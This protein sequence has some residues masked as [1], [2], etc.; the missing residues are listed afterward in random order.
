MLLQSL[1]KFKSVYGVRGKN[2]GDMWYIMKWA[3]KLAYIE[4]REIVM[5]WKVIRI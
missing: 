4:I 2:N 3:F 5:G 1:K